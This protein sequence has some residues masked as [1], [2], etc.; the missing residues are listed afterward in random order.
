M[1]GTNFEEFC[2]THSLTWS[3]TS[4]RSNGRVCDV[5][6]TVTNGKK[7]Q[8][9]EASAS[10]S[11]QAVTIVKRIAF[12]TIQTS[13]TAWK[14]PPAYL[15]ALCDKYNC[16]YSIT[17]RRINENYEGTITLELDPA[18]ELAFS[19]KFYSNI[20]QTASEKAVLYFSQLE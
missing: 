11:S 13:P 7:T 20:H 1:E 10:E 2:K 5:I 3:I 15:N 4:I 6:L 12:E 8:N 17:Y 19:T 9:F 16:K 14:S 18:I